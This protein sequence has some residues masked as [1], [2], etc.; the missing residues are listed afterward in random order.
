MRKREHDRYWAAVCRAGIDG[1]L[2]M[3]GAAEWIHMGW[4]MGVSPEA[5]GAGGKGVMRKR[6][7][8][9]GRGILDASKEKAGVRARRRKRRKPEP[10]LYTNLKRNQKRK[11]RAGMEAEGQKG[12]VMAES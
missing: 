4:G 7:R 3:V 12:R 8:D 11:K 1:N 10:V 5:G 6:A 9:K 2:G